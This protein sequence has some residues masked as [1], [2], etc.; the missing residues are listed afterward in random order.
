MLPISQPGRIPAFVVGILFGALLFLPPG[1]GGAQELPW[2]ESGQ[3]RLDFAPRFW[4]WD[5]RFGL[6]TVDGTI[7]EE[8]EPL[9][10]DLTADP[11]GREIMPHLADLE[12]HVQD[13]LTQSAFRA[14][15]G[16]SRAEV[17]K[18]VLTFPLRLEVGVTDWLTLG[19]TVPFV[20][21]RTEITFALLADST[22]A[23]VGLSPQLTNA[24]AVSQFLTGFQGAIDE[25]RAVDPGSAVVAEA[26]AYIDAL[27]S[28]YGEGTVFP[29]T[30]SATGAALQ[31]RLDA[32]RLSL[33]ELGATDIPTSLP[34]AQQ[35]LA[36][37]QFQTL[38]GS[39]AMQAFPLTDF[40]EPWTLG[41]VEVT[42]GLRLFRRGFQ[43]DSLGDLPTLRYQVGA[44]LL[45]RLGTGTPDDPSRFLDVGSGDGQTDV[46]ASLFGMT[47]VGS[48]FNAWARVRYGVQ[49]E[50]ERSRR[51]AAPEQALPGVERLAPLRWTPGNYL[52]ADLAPRLQLTDAMAVGFRYHLWSKGEDTYG[53][54]PMTGDRPD[55]TE[56]LPPTDLL[57]R[58][59]EET[60]HELGLSVAYS[61][62]EA[63]ARG[64][65]SI[66]VHIR[67]NVFRPLTG[68]GGR[69]P[70]GARIVAGLSLYRD[71]WG[72]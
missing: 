42:A 24:G 26:Q 46:E 61:T 39:Q 5:T 44:G 16:T 43:P 34:L 56:P 55:A 54:G 69:T 49:Q 29:H 11:L 45:L 19:T 7:V 20:R 66:P 41:D 3:L 4:S 50:G 17:D 15:L 23:N 48:H 71:L 13:A 28:A 65:A 58:E 10:L 2:L 53:P 32:L 12:V 21:P 33:E 14:R 25:V 63:H 18:A 51:I 31:E 8:A 9:G 68:S 57:E 37:E 1:N 67:F 6:R 47:E 70:R 62:M 27:T 22:S 72:G 30:E 64:E 36:G 52:E 60:L 40:T 35:Y 59:T 38:L